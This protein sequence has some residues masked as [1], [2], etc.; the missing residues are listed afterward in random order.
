MATKRKRK[1]MW[2]GDALYRDTRLLDTRNAILEPLRRIGRSRNVK[3]I[4]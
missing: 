3:L 2:V 4:Y 1:N